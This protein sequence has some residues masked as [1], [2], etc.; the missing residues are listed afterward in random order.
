MSEHGLMQTPRAPIALM[1]CESGRKFG[2]EVANRLGQELI[3]ST[4]TWF[5]CGEG[6]IE[7]KANVRGHDL[8][9]FQTVIGQQDTRSIY[10]RFVMLLHAIEAGALADAQFITAVLPYYSGA[11]QDKK[12]GGIEKGSALDYLL[13]C[14]RAGAGRVMTVEIHNDAIAEMFNSCYTNLENVTHNKANQIQ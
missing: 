6:K 4:E 8:Y 1:A 5:A 13:A 12:K 2:E 14:Y 11:R 7:I 9:V 10:D 3:P